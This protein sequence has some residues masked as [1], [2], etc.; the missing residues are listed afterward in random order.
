LPLLTPSKVSTI[1]VELTGRC[2]PERNHA[3][4]RRLTAGRSALHTR[5]D[6][7]SVTTTSRVGYAAAKPEPQ[8]PIPRRG[9]SVAGPTGSGK[10][11]IHVRTVVVERV[12]LPKGHETED[13]RSGVSYSTH[14]SIRQTSE[15]P[16]LPLGSMRQ[17]SVH[18]LYTSASG[19]GG[20]RASTPNTKRPC[21]WDLAD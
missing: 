8:S 14:H 3:R 9:R 18:Q 13:E 21:S 7:Q 16:Y 5:V 4:I 10:E 11:R 20:V 15:N 2:Q 17:D 1:I 12:L 19:Y 6:C